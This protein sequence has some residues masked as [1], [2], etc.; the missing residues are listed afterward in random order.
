MLAKRKINRR[1]VVFGPVPGGVVLIVWPVIRW[2]GCARTFAGLR[3]WWLVL[4][5]FSLVR[6]LVCLARWL[7]LVPVLLPRKSCAGV[8]LMGA[9]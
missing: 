3:P 1:M 4:S 9:G 2:P 8:R 5:F 6:F 7:H